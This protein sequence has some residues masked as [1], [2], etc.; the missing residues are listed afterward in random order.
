MHANNFVYKRIQTRC[1]LTQP[2]VQLL[3]PRTGCEQEIKN[4]GNQNLFEDKRTFKSP[5]NT[6]V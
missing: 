4:S 5:K 2:D 1:A 3:E 6:T